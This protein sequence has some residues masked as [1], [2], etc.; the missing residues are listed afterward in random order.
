MT[1]LP[2]S[3]RSR[4]G[5]DE[6]ALAWLQG[7]SEF[8]TQT[9]AAIKRY[10]ARVKDR[11]LVN[12]PNDNGDAL[13]KLLSCGT[14]DPVKLEE[15]I[16]YCNDGYHGNMLAILLDH[17]SKTV[18]PQKAEELA[19]KELGIREKDAVDWRTN[20]RWEQGSSGV[21][22]T[23]Y[24][25]IDEYVRIPQMIDGLPV[26]RIGKNAFKGNQRLRSIQ[27]PET[28]QTIM[29]SAFENCKNLMQID[30]PASLKVLGKRAFYNCSSLSCPTILPEG[31]ELIKVNAFSGCSFGELHIPKSVRKMENCMGEYYGHIY[32]HGT[33]TRFYVPDLSAMI[34]HAPMNSYAAKFRDSGVYEAFF[35]LAD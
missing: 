22:V 13:I 32:F 9:L 5:K 11:L 23:R 35:L 34:V 16:R 2:F 14:T 4:T 25:G 7:Q 21:T 8:D 31:L 15:Y 6:L 26:I 19:D 12:I 17:K 30:L 20:Y 18:T 1:E 29:D 28:V 33:D 3:K 27:I 10:A 24:M